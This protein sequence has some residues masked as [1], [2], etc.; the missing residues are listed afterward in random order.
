M[1]I[2]RIAR[3]R[4]FGIF[5]DFTWPSA[6]RDFGRY[7]LIYGWNGSGK[8][9]LSNLLR[10]LGTRTTVTEG[11]ATVSIDN[12]DIDGD[13][14]DQEAIPIRVFNREFV[15]ETVFTTTDEVA[16]IYVIG[17]D[18]VEK[19]KGV[20]ELE[21]FQEQTRT[22]L[23]QLRRKHEEANKALDDFCI[24]RARLI[25]DT[26]G[27]G[28]ANPYTN[29][30]KSD[31]RQK[32]DKL[33][34][35]ADIKQYNLDDGQRSRRL[36]Q[37]HASPKDKVSEIG[38]TFPDLSSLFQ[39]V[40]ALL[41]RTVVSSAISA[42][43]DDPKLADWVRQGLSLH[44]DRDSQTC[45]FCTNPLTQKR[46]GGLEAHFNDEYE[47]FVK[48]I[49]DALATIADLSKVTDEF[50]APKTAELYDDLSSEY[51]KAL[52]TCSAEVKRVVA[53]LKLL[54]N[55]L[56][57]KKD[58]LFTSQSLP[59]PAPQVDNT[60]LDA[61]NDLLRNHNAAC[62]D[63]QSRVTTAGQQLEAAYVVEAFDEYTRLV[64]TEGAAE[65]LVDK[66]GQTV[67]ETQDKIA[68]IERE[69]VNHRQPADELNRDLREYLGH[70]E[71]CLRIEATGY[72][73]T[74]NGQIANGLSEGEQTAIALLYFLKSLTDTNFNL[75][76]GIVVLDD[77]VSS[78]DANALFCAFGFM[79]ARTQE[80]AQLFVLTHNFMFFRQ[81]C[82]WFHWYNKK[83]N[84]ADPPA[85]FYMLDCVQN[86]NQ[87]CGSIRRL[88]PL[89]EHYESEYHYLF[90]IV[91]RA[92][93][94]PPDRELERYYYL[95]NAAR[96]L[97]EAFLAF[98]LPQTTGVWNQL[99]EIDYDE[100]KKSRIIRFVN[101]LSHLG[102]IGEPQH[103]L[104]ALAE[105]RSVLREVLDLM[106][107]QDPTHYSAMES[108][109]KETPNTETAQGTP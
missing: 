41:A 105:A 23:E 96:R 68:L 27:G 29:Y 103:D 26:I 15:A 12:R 25:K 44:R 63:F 7:N 10:R 31:F 78:L 24:D 37:H 4:D 97:L 79:K 14:F 56:Q 62:D 64:D 53:A 51:A 20:D 38:Y 76:R 80:A 86:N 49:E 42:F 46:L 92:A 60:V 85:C 109:V 32:A 6:L 106:E 82:N 50:S 67:E 89:L 19:Q 43:R 35:E 16:P 107:A 108:L 87:R 74:R 57:A 100:N 83:K 72:Q 52:I 21:A 71:L 91:Y 5:R 104:S 2:T 88:D 54:K 69:I 70:D 11:T 18:N 58:A 95:P 65:T 9:L 102:Q 66:T 39:E 84:K 90:S 94:A 99:Q 101:T 75:S 33:S 73:I 36:A 1:R 48:D 17:K 98:R 13:S 3:L 45:L 77:P 30:N 8:T 22:S 81:V 47:R 59:S 93:N 34:K 28:G 61:A 40:G 55:N